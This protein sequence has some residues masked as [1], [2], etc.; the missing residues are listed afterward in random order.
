[1]SRIPFDGDV[2]AALQAVQRGDE[3]ECPKCGAL[4]WVKDGTGRGRDLPI[5]PGIACSA[6]P[7][8]YQVLFNLSATRERFRVRFG[9]ARED[10]GEPRVGHPLPV[11]PTQK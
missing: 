4:M 7:E 3:L 10:P 5:H 2:E 1:M 8:H 9:G 11:K 6:N